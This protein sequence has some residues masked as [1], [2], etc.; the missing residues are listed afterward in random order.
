MVDSAI[1]EVARP[2]GN[3]PFEI[4]GRVAPTVT[5]IWQSSLIVVH[6]YAEGHQLSKAFCEGEVENS[7]AW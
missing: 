2:V 3:T 6:V 7:T 4:V 1:V 5:Q